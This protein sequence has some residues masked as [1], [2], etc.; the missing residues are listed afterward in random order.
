MTQH[1]QPPAPFGYQPAFHPGPYPYPAGR[2][3]IET[4]TPNTLPAVWAPYGEA[5]QEEDENVFTKKIVGIPVWG[6]AAGLAVLGGG[7]YLYTQM[8]PGGA[9]A[10]AKNDDSEDES[11]EPAAVQPNRKWSPSRSSFGTKIDSFLKKNS[12]R[13]AKVYLDADDAAKSIKTPSPL[14]T[15]RVPRSS[16][17]HTN[18]EFIALCEADGLKPVETAE[19]VVGLYPGKG[20]MGKAWGKYIDDLRDEGQEI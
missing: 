16:P 8:K 3:P 1:D 9:L 6:W 10:L 2:Y 12:V 18:P 14:I 5:A 20:K 15:L 17:L 11:N 7:F 13:G 4:V 19:G